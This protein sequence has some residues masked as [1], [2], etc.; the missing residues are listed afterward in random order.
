MRLDALIQKTFA[1]ERPLQDA[2]GLG[3][4][5]GWDSLGHLNLMVAIESAFGIRWT[6]REISELQ[7]VGEIRRAIERRTN[8]TA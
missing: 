1:F 5:P 3:S 4:V 7:T 2:D 6:T 8:K